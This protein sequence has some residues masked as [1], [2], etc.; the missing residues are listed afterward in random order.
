MSSVAFPTETNH[1]ISSANQMTSFY[2]K[3]TLA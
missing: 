1:F 3:A 2:M